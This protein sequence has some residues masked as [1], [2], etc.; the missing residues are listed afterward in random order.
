MDS[1]IKI[2]KENILKA[3]NNATEENKKML[4][5]LFGKETFKPADIR[6]RIKTFEDACNALGSD[7]QEVCDYHYLVDSK[8]ASDDILAFSKIRII[9]KALNEG[10]K[11]TFSEDEY[12]FYPWYYLYTK[13]E[14][15][16]LS[17]EEKKKNCKKI[18]SID[19]ANCGLAFAYSSH[20][21]SRSD[22]SLS[23]R[24]AFRTRELAEYAAVQFI[25]IYE[26]FMFA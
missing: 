10:W 11:P 18:D 9:V 15:E 6:E 23:A 12:R 22:S 14:Y 1:E 2:Q 7:S 20:A 26:K 3:Y 24:L 19:G 25:E 13:E 17:K 21:W 16:N 5:A 8:C 4:E